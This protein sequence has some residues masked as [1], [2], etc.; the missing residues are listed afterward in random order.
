IRAASNTDRALALDMIRGYA[1]SIMR[2]DGLLRWTPTG[3]AER[4]LTVR[5]L[6]DP[7]DGGT[8]VKTFQIG[9][10]SP[11]STSRTNFLNVAESTPFGALANGAFALPMQFPIAFGDPA[12]S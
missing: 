12:V 3:Q 11:D 10:V 5:L 9:L 7:L 4:A 6:D 8:I 2:A 1:R